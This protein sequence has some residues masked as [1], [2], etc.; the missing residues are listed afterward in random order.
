MEKV[1]KFIDAILPLAIPKLYTYRIPAE[2]ADALQVGQRV[3]VQFGAGTKL[4]GALV[5]RVHEPPPAEYEAKYILDVLDQHP[6]V[7]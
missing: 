7:N 5:K 2:L 1:T 6:I 3:V 4:Y